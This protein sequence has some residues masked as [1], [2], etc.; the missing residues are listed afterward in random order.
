MHT[1]HLRHRLAFETDGNRADRI[2]LGKV[3]LFCSVDDILDDI[4]IVCHRLGIGHTAYGGKASCH[5]RRAAAGDIFFIFKPRL[6]QMR[7]HIYKRRQRSQTFCVIHLVI[8]AHNVL[9]YLDDP[10]VLYC[11]IFLFFTD[12][13]IFDK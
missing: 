8:L 7:V 13:T 12:K 10:V 6:S 2:Y 9:A 11:Y 4:S 1:A 5:C 3:Y